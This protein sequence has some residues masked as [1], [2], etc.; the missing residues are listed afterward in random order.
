[1]RLI[2]LGLFLSSSALAQTPPYDVSRGDHVRLWLGLPTPAT[3][4]EGLVVVAGPDSLTFSPASQGR[5]RRVA[6]RDVGRLERREENRVGEVVGMAVGLAVGAVVG[7]VIGAGVRPYDIE[8][9]AGGVVLG[10][11]A[12]SAV[13]ASVGSRTRQPWAELPRTGSRGT[14]VSF[15][16]TVPLR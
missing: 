3:A 8:R 15:R 10:G 14:V 7:G 6:W 2:L 1:M 11:F 4:V 12:G 16:L 13:G 5:S 9:A